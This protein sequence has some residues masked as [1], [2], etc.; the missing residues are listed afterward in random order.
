M[1]PGPTSIAM[2]P[3]GN[4]T[5]GTA[6]LPF[7]SSVDGQAHAGPDLGA[8][9]WQACLDG[10]RNVDAA[11]AAL[12]D[13]N[14]DFCLLV[15]D[16]PTARPFP[17][18]L[19][20]SLATLARLYA[21][22]V[23][24]NWAPLLPPGAGCIRLPAYPWQKQRLW[25]ART[26]WLTPEPTAPAA[27][28][29]PATAHPGGHH[30]C[31][32]G[33][34]VRPDLVVPYTAPQSDLEKT[35]AAAWSAVLGIEG[36]GVHDNFFELGG[37]S[38]Q[39]T[40]L[41]NRLRDELGETLAGHVLFEVQTIAELA[42][43]IGARS[44]GFSRKVEAPPPQ[45]GTTNAPL[46][47]AQQRLW[48]LDRLDPENPAY[49]I[50]MA[51]RLSGPI[52]LAALDRVMTE[53]VSR[54]E[55]LRTRIEV[56]GDQPCQV[57]S[58]PAPQ[59]LPLVDLSEVEQADREAEAMARAQ[60]EARRPFRLNEG[61]LFR[62]VL[63]RPGHPRSGSA[64]EH[65]LVIVIHHVI[66]DDWSMGV[67]FHELAVLCPALAAG[68]QSP[69]PKLAIQYGEYAAR[70]RQELQGE[71]LDR[72]LN[73]WRQRLEG[74]AMLELPTDRPRPPTVSHAGAV[75]RCV[76]PA[77][78]ANR[79]KELGRREGATLY[80]TLLAAFEVLLH[81]YSGQDDFAVGSPIAGRIHKD[82]EG[83]VG[84][85]ANTLVMRADLAGNPT[86]SETLRRVRQT[87]LDAYQHQEMP[88]EALVEAL[89]PPRDTS[90]HP[91]FQVLFTLQNAPWPDVR[92]ADLT[93]SYVPLDSQTAKFDL[94]LSLRETEAGLQA[95]VEYNTDLFD[96]ATV[97]RMM[98]H[99]ETLLES[100]AA[101]AQRPI[102]SLPMLSEQERRQILVQ[103]NDTAKDYRST[104]C[105]H[106]LVEAQ[107]A[108]SPEAIAVDFEGRQLTYAE[109]NRSANQLARFL[110]RYD[111][112]PDTP[113]GVCL[114]R[115][116]EMVVSLLAILKAGGAYLP[117]DPDYPLERLGFM[118]ADSRPA[119]ILTTGR[120][121]AT[122]PGVE[123]PMV[124]VDQIA[125]ALAGEDDSNLPVR[126]S[127]DDVAYVIYTSGSTG[128][129][130]G[131]RNTHRG[132]TNRLLWMQ[133][134]YGLTADDRVL[135]KTPYSFD[136]SVWEFFWPLLAGARLVL[137]QPGGHKDPRYLVRLIQ[138]QQIT[139]LHFVPSMLAVFLENEEVGGCRSVK[140]VIC[141]GEALSYELQQ[142]FFARLPT[143]L[144]NLYGPTE[145][146]V[147]ATF[148][149][150]RA[151]YRLAGHARIV[152]IGRPIA[153]M[154]CYILDRHQNPL[155][156]GCPGELHLGGVGLAR[157]YLNRPELTAEKFSPHPFSSRPAIGYP[158]ARLY[159]TGDL[160][161]WLPDG[162]IEF[163]GRLDFQVKIRG[164]RIELGEIEAALDAH[165]AV[166]QSVAVVGG[167]A[168][169]PRLAAYFVP[170]GEPSPTA[171]ELREF[172]RKR[173][174]D[175]M[176]PTALVVLD[177]M[178]LT[179]SGKVD[180]K[181]LPPVE[182]QP[183]DLQVAYVA[184]RNDTESRL[185][186]IW[187]E[188][189]RVDRVGIHD[190]FFALGGHSLLAAQ[191][192]A[193]VARELQ[194]ELPLRDL[195]QSPTIAE[196]AERV[197][198][199]LAG[200]RRAL[201][202][203][204]LPAPRDGQLLP[205]FTQEALWFLDQLERGRA[206][207]TIYSPLRIRGPLNVA[208]VERA[209]NEILRRH[210][211]LRTRFPAVDGRPVQV[212]EPPQPSTLPLVDLSQLPETER[213]SRLR[214][215][216]AEEMERPID[217]QNGPLI[218]ITLYRL[219]DDNHVA[220]VSAHHIIYDGW[221]MAVLL[222]ELSALYT[223]FESG[224]PSP[225]ANPPIQYADFA[226]WQRQWLQG[227]EIRRLRGYWVKQLSDLSPLE[228]PLDHSRPGIRTTRGATRYFELSAET[229]AALLD[230]CRREGV[231]PFE[232]LLAAFQVL[233]MRYS[234]QEDFAIG[235]PVANR[236]RPEIE[237][238]I[239]YF[240]NVVV[241]RNDMSGDPSFRELLARLRR[242]TLDAYDHQ[243]MTLDQVVAAVNPPRDMSRHPL[244]QVMFALQNIELPQLD[245]FG[246]SMTPLED[247]PSPRSSYFDLTLA[248]WQSGAVFRGELNFSTDL[249]A[250]ETID[251][252]AGHYTTLLAEAVARPDALLSRLPLLSAEERQQLLAGW[253]QTAA[254]YPRD[255]CVHE[256]FAA[257]AEETPEAVA[258]VLGDERWTYRELND[259]ANQLARHLRRQ[260]V[261][262]QTRVGIC[263]ERSPQ[264]VMAV[265]GVLK[266]GGAYVPLDPAY[267]RDAEERLNYVRED[268]QVGLVIT[269]TDFAGSLA[270]M[271][272]ELLV[273]DGEVLSSAADTA[274]PV[275]ADAMSSTEYS[276]PRSSNGDCPQ[277]VQHCP[278]EIGAGDE[279]LT[280]ESLAYILYTSGSTGRPKGVMVT[281]RNL[282]NAYY[283]LAR[284]LPAGI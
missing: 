211:A 55:T 12:A 210:E 206:T 49:N 15:G 165:P 249:F 161:R 30:A 167:D 204:I 177:S 70:Q 124:D 2:E 29:E 209:L 185:V 52:D 75:H 7:L 69:L 77:A 187:Q 71:T 222:S 139:T 207:Y 282:V 179:A 19:E 247:G 11:A 256:L 171:D 116:P 6:Q 60:V 101:D 41:L 154:E 219:A 230:F 146:A 216:I 38:L 57:V 138:Q 237:N 147:D 238:L 196:L 80:M 28:V 119:A 94:W 47:F 23:D 212:I 126:N 262:I 188:I 244:F 173:L 32:V 279:T 248:L 172:L 175:F 202:P 162:N 182:E 118:I 86:F 26:K 5:P 122:L 283:G 233:L 257:R 73:Y 39:A 278:A 129:P 99:F 246:L 144:H 62:A 81:R 201:G 106:E 150:C 224:R 24:L 232:T 149:R 266:A 208:T 102:G 95:E 132:I 160:C 14:A 226:A 260:G 108:R 170:Q 198:A 48:L 155:P 61:P 151:G 79:V 270:A 180:R 191:V 158:G 90:R 17:A 275:R 240:V 195:F 92:L 153:N 16:A 137:A 121:A 98:G 274:E 20:P 142:R 193:R 87:A 45:G 200:G 111:L 36:I 42:A 168:S 9:H 267:T 128:R 284:R 190:N 88:F 10:R 64:T 217:L 214:Q 252:M 140:R 85:L 115:S 40:I 37:D 197:H 135:Q 169:N 68:R 221:S 277:P 164:N 104:A 261:G 183:R 136:V 22:G 231:T 163:L 281:H 218:R 78:L 192:A 213:E 34:R 148:W 67:L 203:P 184:P 35:L 127:W 21:A 263:M 1:P 66:T 276:V 25:A 103:W 225:L 250:A 13:R 109:L 120:L 117:L 166:R 59:K 255:A 264:L 258:V 100:I 44:T 110:A 54:H 33:S 123:A 53:I 8:V 271:A 131:V 178:P 143:E 43:Y 174:P 205:S 27:A 280:A 91:L 152:P 215:G 228:L 242:T 107:V 156:V 65:I 3:E 254:D 84:F 159:R 243:A 245:S 50:P 76:L 112:Q 235:T 72:L 223:A 253:N 227:E 125:D 234:G 265:L 181:A 46:S 58:P 56:V 145:A 176:I 74:L 273:L 199:S 51:L 269:S 194:A 229:S 272:K 268:A 63:L 105:L 220:M 4:G 239:G 134:A 89:N 236:D 241:L 97:A 18:P 133:D 93:I 259:R 251:R 31:M 83:L 157:D 114:E 186:D 113:V 130:K 96:A 189:L 141:S 82:T